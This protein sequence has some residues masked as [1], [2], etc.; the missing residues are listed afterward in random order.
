MSGLS[1]HV[2]D[3]SRGRP[4]A[5]VA[6]RL[7]LNDGEGWRELGRAETDDDGRVEDLL[8][9]TALSTGDY[10]LVFDTGAYHAR[11]GVNGFHPEVTIAF[12]VTDVGEHHHVPLLLSP[13]GYTTY[14]GS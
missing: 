6:V 7:E 5:G 13:F 10:R 12:T 1:T 4:G 2:L 14:R 8:G 9:S 11:H 3:V